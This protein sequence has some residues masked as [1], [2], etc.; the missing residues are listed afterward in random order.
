MTAGALPR[1]SCGQAT[2]TCLAAIVA[3]GI[4]GSAFIDTN[5]FFTTLIW[6]TAQWMPLQS[7]ANV[8]QQYAWEQFSSMEWSRNG[9]AAPILEIQSV[10][11]QDHKDDVL[12]YLES[13]YGKFWI[14][15]PVLFR[16]LW[17][18]NALM[19]SNRRLSLDGLLNQNL[20]I[21]YFSD[22]RL[23]DLT[24]DANAPVKDIVRNITMGY[25]HK[26]GTQLLVQSYPELI[27]EV[28]PGEL[29]TKLFGNHFQPRH[30]L[31]VGKTLGLF[32]GTTTVPVF[33]A[34]LQSYSQENATCNSNVAEK[35]TLNP[36]PSLS[37]HTALHCEPI[38]NVA[39]Q[40]SGSRQWLLIDPKHSSKL[41]PSLDPDG[42]G[43]FA[44][45]VQSFDH[46][47]RYLVTTRAGDAVWVPTWTWHRVDYISSSGEDSSISI[48][49]SLFH[50]RPLEFGRRNPLYALLIM[51][52]LIRELLGI[53]TQ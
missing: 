39:V 1:G 49:A 6:S 2:M 43:F 51:P 44:S 5:R 50:F 25:P 34:N 52:A 42:R 26:F 41:N 31:G 24:P 35:D 36:E 11:V 29:V 40:L 37:S 27:E 53:S 48:G 13:N 32:P 17:D 16:G 30:I 33:V 12:G 46:V 38:G 3:I 45:W 18:P 9:S 20:T 4:V 21:P 19:T 15:R 14:D 8:L 7:L 22:A 23:G 10:S 47:P 28:A